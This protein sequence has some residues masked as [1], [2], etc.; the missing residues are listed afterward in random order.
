[1][2]RKRAKKFR[3]QQS[4][5]WEAENKKHEKKLAREIQGAAKAREEEKKNRATKLNNKDQKHEQECLE[6]VKTRPSQMT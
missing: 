6:L 3:M 5:I 4:Y 1:M 2:K